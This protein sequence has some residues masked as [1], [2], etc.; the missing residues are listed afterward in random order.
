MD[1]AEEVALDEIDT[2]PEALFIERLELKVDRVDFL[3]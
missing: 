1:T 2:W 3:A